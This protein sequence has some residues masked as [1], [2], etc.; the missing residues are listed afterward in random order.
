[1]AGTV[2]Q[3]AVIFKSPFQPIDKINLV[4]RTAYRADCS[5]DPELRRRHPTGHSE[6]C[7]K[8]KRFIGARSLRIA[9]KVKVWSCDRKLFS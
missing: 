6:E 8:V 2:L 9:P 4:E 3:L 5:Q 1:M 7:V